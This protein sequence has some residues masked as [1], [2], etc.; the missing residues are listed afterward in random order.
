MRGLFFLQ[1]R[2]I[3]P[4]YESGRST[5]SH[6]GLQVLHIP[7]DKVAYDAREI[8]FLTSAGSTVL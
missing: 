4:E 3:L 1:V 6:G 2:S 7:A 5:S 8:A